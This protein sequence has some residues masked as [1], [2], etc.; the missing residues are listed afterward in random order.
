VTALQTARTRLERFIAH[1]GLKHTRQ[2][3]MILE[4]FMGGGRHLSV[5]EVLRVVQSAHPAIGAA[6]V[7]RTLKLF[8]DAGVALERNFGD[9][10]ARYEPA[11]D[12]EHHDHLICSDCNTIFE[13]E[14]DEIERRQIEVATRHGLVMHAHRHE[15]HGRCV[16][17]ESCPRWPGS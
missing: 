14:D 1:Q 2:R 13:F 6:T 7:Y 15:I 9:G 16:A 17:R 12:N 3:D 4:A 8:V 10:Q 11:V 5:D